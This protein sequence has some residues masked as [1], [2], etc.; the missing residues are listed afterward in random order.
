MSCRMETLAFCR[1][2]SA[3]QSLKNLN[4]ELLRLGALKT[5]AYDRLSRIDTPSG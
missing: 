4:L 2:S 1:I 3:E 5:I